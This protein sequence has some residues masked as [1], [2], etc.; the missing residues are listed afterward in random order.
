MI[1]RFFGLAASLAASSV[2]AQSPCVARHE[3]RVMPADFV[4]ARVF[5]LWH[6]A[7]GGD[8]RLYTDTGGGLV[9]LTPAAAQRLG[10]KIDTTPRTYGTQHFVVLSTHV[11]RSKLDTLF[12]IPERRDSTS[13]AFSVE[14]EPADEPGHAWDG[15]LG[16]TWFADRVWTIDYP[17]KRLFFN[18]TSP[19]G[20]S[21]PSC[22]VPLGFRL[23]SV[24]HRIN[25]FPRIR[26]VID[27]D[28]L[29][30][31]LDTGARTTLT[32][33]AHSIINPREPIHRAAS[34]IIADR[35]QAWHTRHPDW[36]VIAH[37]EQETG[38]DMIRVPK[39]QVGQATFGPVWFTYRPNNN[40]RQFMSQYMDQPIEGA[41]G[42]SA[43]RYTTL[44]IDYP[45]SRAAVILPSSR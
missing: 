25:S 40:F 17:G 36:P 20:P 32:D 39:V 3:G 12:P 41:L 35:F 7:S 28:T 18:G 38:F 33:A 23:D 6:L 11:P 27:G 26:V 42:G 31:L 2:F 14:D 4:G 10:V 24:G 21:Q 44:I 22:W 34:F 29:Q 5:A 13:V 9:A 15:R 45:R 30:L 16:T 43:W 1:S 37:A 8:L 19:T